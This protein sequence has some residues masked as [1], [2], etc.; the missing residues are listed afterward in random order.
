MKDKLVI[1][2]HMDM[3]WH[4]GKPRIFIDDEPFIQCAFLVISVTKGDPSLADA[5]VDD[6]AARPGA[7]VLEGKDT[8]GMVVEGHPITQADVMWAFASSI[9]GWVELGYNTN[10]LGANLAFPLLKELARVG[11]PKAK[12]VLEGE[13][14]DR[15][16]GD[17]ANV[18]LVIID[19]CGDL[20]DE[21]NWLM[22]ARS[23]HT[24]VRWKVA[25]NTPGP[26]LA[27]LAGDADE[28]VRRIVAWNTN[29]PGPAL[30]RL[31]GDADVDVRREVA[32]NTSMSRQ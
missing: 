26:A 9:I 1:N 4:E 11:D 30:A 28:D 29:T 31:A 19:T 17:H 23:K 22:L 8:V 25:R 15:L 27:R 5:S 6:L 32:R 13:I 10:A 18:S 24:I 3:R 20:L 14:H 2:E 12:R 16:K 7:S 21:E